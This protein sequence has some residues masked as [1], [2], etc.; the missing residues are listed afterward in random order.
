MKS[1]LPRQLES[2]LANYRKR[3][4]VIKLTEA[5]LAAIFCLALSY[6]IIFALDRVME[7]PAWL[8][9]LV[10]GCGAL[11]L[12][13]GLPLKWYRWVWKQRQLEDA[14]RLIRRKL[15]RLGDQ[16]LGIV[17]LARM[18]SDVAGQSSTLVDAAIEQ[19][20]DAVQDRDLAEAV[21]DPRHLQWS[22]AA[23]LVLGIAVIGFIFVSEA[24]WNTMARWIAPWQQVDRFTFARVES[25][26]EAR[27][28]PYAEPFG[29]QVRLADSTQWSPVAGSGRIAKQARIYTQLEDGGY[30][31]RFPPQKTDV[32]MRMAL[33]DVRKSILVQPRTRPELTDIAVRLRLP[34]YLEYSEELQ[35]QVRGTTVS[36]VEGAAVSFEAKTDRELS[37]AELDG[38]PQQVSG[39]AIITPYE[40]VTEDVDKS[41][42]WTD[43][44]GL[45]PREPLSVR[46][47]AVA[48]EA[49]TISARRESQELVVLESEVITFD[50][51][52]E[53]DF[54]I[55]NIGVEW[56][57]ELI[58]ADS[59]TPIRGER[60]AASGAPKMKQIDTRATFCASREGISPQTLEVRLWAEDYL[61]A[62]ERSRSS[63]FVLQIVDKTE[64]ALWLTDQFSKWLSSAK[65]SYEREQLL[66]QTNKELRV[67]SALDLDRPENRRRVSQQAAAEVAQ[68]ARMNGLTRSG[69]NLVEQATKNDEFDAERL[70]SWATMLQTLQDIAANRMPSVADQLK[71]A[72]AAPGVESPQ[73]ATGQKSSPSQTVAGEAATNKELAAGAKPA[74]PSISDRES[75]YMETPEA[76]PSG[77]KPPGGGKLKLPTTQMAAAPGQESDSEEAPRPAESPAQETMDQAL[78][79]QHDLL[80]EFAAVADQ[81]SEILASLETSTFV[82]RLK[83]ASREQMG[84]A[85]DIGRNT[86]TSF[87]IKSAE[88]PAADEI[89]Q[90]GK[91][92]SEIVR[93]IQGDL[94]AYF[95][96]K[97]DA[98]YK[99]ILDE[100]Q[101]MQIVAALA[102][103]SEKVPANLTGQGMIGC[104]YWAD[105][106]DRWAEELVAASN[107]KSCSSCSGDSLPPEIVLKVVQALHDEMQLRDETRELEN[108]KPALKGEKYTARAGAL[109]TKQGD[110]IE[111]I[112][113]AI[114][115]IQAIPLGK[116]KF[117]KELSL[118][119]TVSS[120]MIEAQ[121]ILESPD[122]G[123]PA[124]AAETEAIEL[125]LQAKRGGGGGGGGGSPGGG[126]TAETAS[127]AALADIGP[128]SDT[129]SPMP[130][131]SVDGGTGRA[132]SEFPAEFSRGLDAYFNNLE[133]TRDAP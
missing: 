19:A 49:P 76:K 60:L 16:L 114:S 32:A 31:F 91:A 120:V 27:V 95:H 12:G 101:D 99:N 113:S 1:Q 110:I 24:A 85:K 3:V 56:E 29:Q 8:R 11:A 73:L 126:G 63:T 57:G 39:D 47:L 46:L 133:A 5:V 81:L 70:E 42:A 38:V 10:L 119:A 43:H 84:L 116:Q 20:A 124:I 122:T 98:R 123:D 78:A 48:D 55:K 128:G 15:P 106:L 72:A 131:R 62:R 69:R 82:K 97:Q 88:V 77:P 17:E 30:H 86:L 87:G 92:Q 102:R 96:R 54:G 33:G 121:A 9:L 71:R 61:P 103:G 66:Y 23:G 40:L 22:W 132:G 75:G 7:T 28:V 83:L 94:R 117:A 53:D 107:C 104:E 67:L 6:L 74:A 118:L 36:V 90:K 51:D 112:E 65:E 130:L 89:E 93:V 115:D 4:R 34:A 127:L 25:L 44:Y 14:A 26:P 45:S 58:Q 37:A 64:H 105:T 129:L 108:T 80:A 59:D 68:A 109:S 41:F 100:M 21:P 125:L 35:L 79:D 52:A 50:I 111:H 18:G 13:L 2:T